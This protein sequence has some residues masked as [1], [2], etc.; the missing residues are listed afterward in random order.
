MIRFEHPSASAIPQSPSGWS[1]VSRSRS[2]SRSRSVARSGSVDDRD[3]SPESVDGLN[4]AA[5]R[6]RQS[7]DVAE[8]P[9]SPTFE[10]VQWWAKPMWQAMEHL[11]RG[12]PKEQSRKL[13]LHSACTGTFMEKFVMDVFGMSIGECIGCDP[14]RASQEFVKANISGVTH[15]FND[16]D[17]LVN[18]SGRCSKHDG[19]CHVQQSQPDFFVMGPPCQPH[20]GYR[21]KQGKTTKTGSVKSHPDY[22]VISEKF[23]RYIKKFLPLVAIVEEVTGFG[24]DLPDGT[25]CLE[26]LVSFLSEHYEAVRVVDLNPISWL[27][28]SRPRTLLARVYQ[29][30]VLHPPS[31]MV[32][33]CVV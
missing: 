8:L 32:V 12:L 20:T 18:L 2:R 28:I 6:R 31:V 5:G 25:N 11:R 29:M 30:L 14:K 10:S 16:L 33:V 3:G 1:N 27:K 19:E 7:D 9:I 21:Y 13:V 4:F 17:D 15:F 26:D 22:V 23:P 24:D